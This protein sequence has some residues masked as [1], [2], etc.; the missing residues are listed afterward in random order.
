MSLPLDPSKSITTAPSDRSFYSSVDPIDLH[1]LL[2][3][4]SD[5]M[6]PGDRGYPMRTTSG[7]W[8]IPV[9]VDLPYAMLAS[10]EA[11][12]QSRVIGNIVRAALV[13]AGHGTVDDI[14]GIKSDRYASDEERDNIRDNI[15][16]KIRAATRSR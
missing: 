7:D 9:V 8:M 13:K 15:R 5:R 4:G 11:E 2:F 1:R 12:A 14:T 16:D 6:A 10:L 3:T